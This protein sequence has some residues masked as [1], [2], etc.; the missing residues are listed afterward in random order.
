MI[1]AESSVRSMLAVARAWPRALALLLLACVLLQGT[2][3]QAHLHFAQQ[4]TLIAASADGLSKAT[5]PGHANPTAE[6]ALC[7]EA[8]LQGAYVLPPVVVLPAPP[9]ST[10][11]AAAASIR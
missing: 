8:A 1:S 5:A 6:C 2:A 3:I 9:A 11:L 10:L 7:Q 4:A